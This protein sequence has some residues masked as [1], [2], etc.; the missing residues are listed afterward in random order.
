MEEKGK[1]SRFLGHVPAM[2]IAFL[3]AAG[4]RPLAIAEGA[5]PKAIQTRMGHSSINVTLDR[6]GHLFPELDQAIATS[7]GERLA[8]ARQRRS[9]NVMHA[10]FGDQPRSEGSSSE[11]L[12]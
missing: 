5:H 2:T 4:P 6:Y 7:F 10:S 12:Q 11:G 3:G 8:A 1:L 9:T